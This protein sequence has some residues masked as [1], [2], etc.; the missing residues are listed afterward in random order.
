[1]HAECQG[2]LGAEVE[3]GR[4]CLWAGI[5]QSR[6]HGS[7]RVGEQDGFRDISNTT[8]LRAPAPRGPQTSSRSLTCELVS[9]AAT[10]PAQPPNHQLTSRR[11][12]GPPSLTEELFQTPGSREAEAW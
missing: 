11:P 9:N 12:W 3:G 6:G 4:G 7:W 5:S 8:P 10:A 2:A 1:M